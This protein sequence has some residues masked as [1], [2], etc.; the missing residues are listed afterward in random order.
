MPKKFYAE[1]LSLCGNEK[2][3]QVEEDT[4]LKETKNMYIRNA[5]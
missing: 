5:I 2:N 3:F 4:Q 1:L